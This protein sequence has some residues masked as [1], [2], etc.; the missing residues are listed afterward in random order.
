MPPVMPLPSLNRPA[1]IVFQWWLV[2][3]FMGSASKC[4]VKNPA[5]MTETDTRPGEAGEA[6]YYRI[7][8]I[9]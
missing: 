2:I 5:F 3:L 8:N 1:P 6:K 7:G 4:I 9:P